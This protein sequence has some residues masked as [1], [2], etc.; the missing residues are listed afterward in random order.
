MLNN[1]VL[2]LFQIILTAAIWLASAACGMPIGFS[3]ILLPQLVVPN[4]SEHLLNL[5]SNLSNQEPPLSN[6][7]NLI[8]APKWETLYMDLELASWV[9][10]VHSA[11]TPIGCFIS[12]PF[13]DRFGRKITLLVSI[14]PLVISWVMMALS[15]SHLMIIAARICGGIAVGFL[16]APA[17]IYI[18]E[19]AEPHLRGMLVGSP[20]VAYSFGILLEFILGWK[21]SWRVVAW[22]GIILPCI[23]WVC[24]L[25]ANESP[26]WLVRNQR[27]EEAFKSMRWLRDTD[28]I[29]R[30]EVN[31]LVERLE[32]EEEEDKDQSLWKIVRQMEVLKPLIIINLFNTFQILSGT[33]MI[34]F[35]AVQIIEEFTMTGSA[36]SGSTAAV[37]SAISRL[38]FT[39]MYCFV[40]MFVCRRTMLNWAGS[41]AAVSSFLLGFLVVFK[42]QL[43]PSTLFSL[44]CLLLLTYLA[45]STCLFVMCG[46]GVGELLPSKVRGKI[47]GYIF[48]YMNIVLFFLVKIFPTIVRHIG[49]SGL[50]FSFSIGS[51]LAT[52]TMYLFMPETKGRKLSEIEDYFMGSNWLWRSRKVN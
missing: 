10:S 15:P 40:L 36:I 42:H 13:T 17:Q 16:A 39:I 24:L 34:V 32:K 49:I 50:F 8:G 38:I 51:F 43:D 18:A 23:S 2:C 41:V 14:V 11:S 3:S 33:F 45:G 29:A 48:S 30:N 5:S 12:A 31:E 22:A 4:V 21:F 7:R 28:Q 44:A 6:N 37:F 20:F 52:L 9:S 1:R 35:Y 26:V 19:I 46:V 25:F 47:S 27:K